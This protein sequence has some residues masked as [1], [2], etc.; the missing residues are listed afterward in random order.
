MQILG[1]ARCPELMLSDGLSGSG[2]ALY[3]KACEQELEGVVAKRQSSAYA[4]G[5]RNGAWVK[6][7]RRL[8]I[9]VAILGFIEKPKRDFQSLLVAGSAL[10]GEA[11]GPLRYLGRVG[12]G[13]TEAMR[14]QMND[15]LRE[16]P[17]GAP[18]VPCPERGTWVQ[19]GLYCE[20][21]Y[22]ELTEAGL[23]R[24]PVFEGMVE[25]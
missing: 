18:L 12:G 11:P 10:P 13:F 5:K 16:H 15:R 14:A 1:S 20:V 3:A 2:M 19:P 8:R 22:A 17:R 21:S 4:A 9:Q 25:S 6:I 24:A 7:K 23:L